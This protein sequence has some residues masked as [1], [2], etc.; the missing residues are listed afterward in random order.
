MPKTAF[1]DFRW[2]ATRPGRA[3]S[4]LVVGLLA[5]WF[6]FPIFSM[7]YTEGFQAETAINGNALHQGNVADAMY[8]FVGRFFLLTR[9]GTSLLVSGLQRLSGVDALAAFRLI[10]ITSMALMLGSLMALLWRVYR[11]GPALI[12]L[13]CILFPA[14]FEAGYLPNDDLPS[15]ALVCLAVLLFWTKPTI[16]RTIATGLLLGVAALLRLDAVLIAPAFAILLLTEVQ[17]W[18]A[19]AIRAVICGMLVAAI[20][21]LAYRLHG[22]SFFDAFGAVDA[23]LRLW[24]RPAT[25]LRNDLHTLV[26]GITA[27]GALAWFLGI[28]SF[29]RLQR[30]RDFTLAVAVPAFY[31]VAYRAQLIEGRYLLPLGPFILPAMALGLRSVPALGRWRRL[32]VA[33]FA[34]GY[35]IWIVPPLKL[36]PNRLVGDEDG[37]HFLIGRAWNPLAALWWQGRL[38][39]GQDAVAAAV[40]RVAAS[41]GPVIVTGDW[42]SDRLVALALLEQ[43]FTLRPDQT[44]QACRGIAETLQRGPVTLLQIRTHIPFLPHHSERVAWTEAGLPCLHAAYPSMNQ[45]L[46]VGG[47]P[48]D[49]LPA[50]AEGARVAFSATGDQPPLAPKLAAVLEGYFVAEMPVDEV[51][52]AFGPKLPADEQLAATETLASRA[53]LLR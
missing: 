11:V 6:I 41:P 33:G 35:A 42:T 2:L 22:L 40:A 8:P 24:D 10:A 30:W 14:L 13:C 31:V 29:V 20:P 38:N 47:A 9:L 45:V 7:A 52:D 12:L 3:V 26:L 4:L 18:G 1:L 48:L 21:I 15:A 23:A 32:A 43:G 25:P 34:V 53:A 5:A 27:M 50:A 19:R 17:G 39:A 16:P 36:L 46:V 49:K 44:P 51:T 37:P 28:V